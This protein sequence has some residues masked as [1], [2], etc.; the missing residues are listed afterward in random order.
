MD[1]KYN[2]VKDSPDFRDIAYGDTHRI[3]GL[4]PDKVDLRP[5]CSPIVNQ[6]DLGSCTANAIVSGLREYYLINDEK[7]PLVRLS[8][9]FLYWWERNMEGTVNED[10]GASLRDGMKAIC[11]YGTCTEER[12]PYIEAAFTE[13][14]SQAEMQEALQ[15]RLP[16]Y[17]R[18]VG[19]N[20]IKDVLVRNHPVAMSME[21]FQSFESDQAEKTGIIPVPQQ[22]E[23]SL[24]GHA[25]TIVGYDDNMNGGSFIIRNSWGEEWGDKGY[26][27]IPYTMMNYFYDAWTVKTDKKDL[28]DYLNIV[29]NLVSFIRIK[30]S[31][32]M[33]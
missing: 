15:Y 22:G 7:K 33:R 10:S 24:G 29:T 23:Q 11:R 1:R 6:G 9:L 31:K 8:R 4:Y 14:P 20:Q 5:K 2:I 32:L 3:R 12:D 26:C 18:L 28:G 25:M 19:L 17:Q 13:Q 21:L 16:G 27:Y 30:L